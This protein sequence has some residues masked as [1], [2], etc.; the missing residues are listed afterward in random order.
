MKTV[1]FARHGESEFSVLGNVNGD[2]AVAVRLTE[3]GQ[4]QAR[5][6]GGEIAADPIELCV[7][8]EFGRTRETADIALGGRDLPRL[9]LPDLNDVRFGE[10]EGGPLDVY[11]EWAG[12]NL[13]TMD[14]PG[15]GESRA[16]TVLRYVRGYRALL[17]RPE[18]TILAVVHGLPI[19]YVLNALRGEHPA[20]IVEQVPYA[21]PYRVDAPE[22]RLAAQRLEAWAAHPE[23]PRA[24]A[25]G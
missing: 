20:P 9:V 21:V 14:A 12:T 19:R 7:V 6:L 23:W 17:E 1:I 5:Q 4:E 25:P 11:R 15:G 18:A 3:T 2:P 10:F 24:A 22:L 16:A 13:P 8:T